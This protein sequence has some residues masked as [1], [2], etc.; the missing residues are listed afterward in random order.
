MFHERSKN[1][2]MEKEPVGLS[3]LGIKMFHGSGFQRNGYSLG[4]GIVFTRIAFWHLKL[5]EPSTEEA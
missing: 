5:V 1:A 4:G 2:H 3:L